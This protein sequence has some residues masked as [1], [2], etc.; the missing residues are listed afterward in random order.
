LIN[1]DLFLHIESNT[2]SN[3]GILHFKQIE[4]SSIDAHSTPKFNSF[5][6]T[7]ANNGEIGNALI[8]KFGWKF[9]I[10]PEE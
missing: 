7:I 10:I 8:A 1:S 9:D 4:T 3:E 6:L 2:I 5:S